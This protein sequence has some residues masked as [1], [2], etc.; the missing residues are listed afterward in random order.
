[1]RFKELI[2][3]DWKE[4]QKETIIHY[5]EV[6]DFCS[7]PYPN[8]PNGCPNIEKCRKLKHPSIKELLSHYHNFYL[9]YTEFDFDAY[10]RE[11]NAL[12]PDFFNTRE[13]LE[14]VLYWQ[15]PVKRL[16]EKRLDILWAINANKFYVL[17]SGSGLEL[18]FQKSVPSMENCCIN[19]FSTM[20]LNNI[21]FELR[22][23]RKIILCNLLCADAPLH[24]K[25][26]NITLKRWL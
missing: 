26:D 11:R 20:K 2:K 8:H 1:M 6:K 18:T 15:R 22:P 12:N 21:E 19:V 24:F 25:F 7:R 13:R 4:I 17:G 14:C 3:I 23:L 5:P 16:I 10:K 9:F